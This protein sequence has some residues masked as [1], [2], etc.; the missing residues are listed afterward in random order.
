MSYDPK[1]FKI[2]LPRM[3]HGDWPIGHDC[4][5]EEG[6]HDAVSNGHGAVSIVLSDGRLLGVKPG[7][8]ERLQ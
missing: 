2:Y 3:V 4:I 1:I 5:A 8:F 6:I 7:E